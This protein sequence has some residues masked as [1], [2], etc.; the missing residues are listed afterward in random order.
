MPGSFTAQQSLKLVNVKFLHAADANHHHHH[1]TCLSQG[2]L[3]QPRVHLRDRHRL[4]GQPLCASLQVRALC[5]DGHQDICHAV[6]YLDTFKELSEQPANRT[7]GREP[8]TLIS[9]LLCSCM[10]QF[11]TP[12]NRISSCS[13]AG[14]VDWDSLVNVTVDWT[15]QCGYVVTWLE[16]QEDSQIR[17]LSV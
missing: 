11:G 14:W 5:V 15:G 3:G 6:I 8:S 4:P 12:A 10:S 16:P 7:L 13:E 9:E 2:H 1:T 17:R